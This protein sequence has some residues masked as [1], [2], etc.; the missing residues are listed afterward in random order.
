MRELITYAAIDVDDKSYHLSILNEAT[1][2]IKTYRT[3]PSGKHIVN[4]LKKVVQNDF[5]HI[6]ICYE[7]TYLG[8]SLC[9]EL[10][11]HGLDCEVIAS[12]LIP[13]IKGQKVKTDRL[14]SEKLVEFYAKGLLTRVNLPTESDEQ[15]RD[16]LRSRDFLLN[17]AKDIKRHVLAICRRLGWSY[18]QELGLKT[19]Q[20]WTIKHR[21]WLKLKIKETDSSLVRFNM[22][23]LLKSLEQLLDQ[24][25]L[26]DIEI[27][28]LAN[29][30]KYEKKVSAL[31][32]FRGIKTTTAMTLV[33]EIGDIKR[34]N[35]P[36]KLSSFSGFDIMEYSSGG[37]ERKSSISRMG[38]AF[39]RTSVVEAAQ[40]AARP[41]NLSRRLKEDRLGQQDE[42][43]AIADKCMG[44]LYKK[45]SRLKY[46]NKQPNK[47]KVACAREMLG[48]IWETLNLVS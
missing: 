11:S 5:K 2:E 16:L 42:V 43:I 9:R 46:K 18:K 17:E 32:C 35:H 41:P 12:S 44:R 20:Y 37:V 13:D 34:F 14:D 31:K 4:K 45:S 47:V 7:S 10:R 28:R 38:N 30:E 15:A 3:H 24:V 21:Q 39:I 8:F 29:S 27:V 22:T 36:N 25:E 6:K 23:H 19:P 1:R 40:S 48:F 26:Y 33:T